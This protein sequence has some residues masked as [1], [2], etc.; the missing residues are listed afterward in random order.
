[1]NLSGMINRINANIDEVVDNNEAVRWLNDGKD[2]MAIAAKAS[3]PDIELDSD[4]SGSFVFD[5]R[6]HMG[7][8]LYAC[9][10]F[11]EQS[12]SIREAQN[13]LDQFERLNREFA[14]SFSVPDEY[15]V[16][17]ATDGGLS[18]PYSWWSW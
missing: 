17:D 8:V 11:K 16:A 18:N 9:A 3:F 10:K 12:S 6:F 14:N 4:L 5:E 15:K 1:M 7:P 13:F 2:I